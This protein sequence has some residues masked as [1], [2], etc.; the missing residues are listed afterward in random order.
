[1]GLPPYVR[2]HGL[3]VTSGCYRA[4]YQ[5]RINIDLDQR[6]EMVEAIL[7]SVTSSLV[8]RSARFYSIAE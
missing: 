7:L 5:D 8:R 6:L 2:R 4:R 1:V 3:R